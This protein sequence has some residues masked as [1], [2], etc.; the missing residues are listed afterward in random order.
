MKEFYRF[1]SQTIDEQTLLSSRGSNVSKNQVGE[2]WAQ[3]L[4]KPC[5]WINQVGTGNKSPFSL[6]AKL[7]SE[8]KLEDLMVAGAPHSGH[9]VRATGFLVFRRI[10]QLDRCAD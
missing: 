1:L 4:D 7:A 6:G 3:H 8:C 5:A 2:L 10:E 9:L